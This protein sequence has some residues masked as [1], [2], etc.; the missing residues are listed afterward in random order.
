MQQYKELILKAQEGITFEVMEG[1]NEQ[2]IITAFLTITNHSSENYANPPVP[3]G[4]EHIYGEWN[5]GFVIERKSDGSQFVWV[6]VSTLYNKDRKIEIESINKYGGFYISRFNIS[7]GLDE[8]P[9]SVQGKLPWTSITY[10]QAKKLA[11]SMEQSEN[12][13]SHLT[14]DEEYDMVLKWFISS[15]AVS[16]AEIYK[17]SSG[18]GNYINS[19]N[20]TKELAKTGSSEEWC[21][22][23]IYDFIGN[24]REW[25]RY[26]M[27]GGAAIRGGDF[28]DYGSRNS[29]ADRFGGSFGYSSY[30]GV[31]F[32]VVL[33]IK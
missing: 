13:E 3:E 18:L 26:W 14:F 33:Y 32:R 8:K 19:I 15:R 29:A 12:V 2:I 30:V 23:N 17:D 31:G 21:I 5:N 10:N 24:V 1:D 6:P 11:E 27:F 16:Y 25:T 9:Q 22:N 4:Y 28:T 20:G 7:K